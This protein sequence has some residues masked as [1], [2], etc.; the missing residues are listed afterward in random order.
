MEQLPKWIEDYN[1]RTSLKVHEIALTSI[2]KKNINFQV[3][4]LFVGG[5]L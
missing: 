3:I 5:T 1:E 4:D 2:Y